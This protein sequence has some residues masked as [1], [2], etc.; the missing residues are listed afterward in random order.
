MARRT[1]ILYPGAVYHLM[2]RGNRKCPIFQNDD[3]R[4]TFVRTVARAVQRYDLRVYA[5]CLMDNH[6]HLLAETPRANIPAVMQYLNGVY[7]RA[8]N[9]HHQLTGHLF[10]DRYRALV[11]QRERYLR[12][13]ARY[14][15]LNP[16]RARLT[17][18]A[19]SWP[20][21]TYRATAG[22][23]PA[24]PWL[25]LSWLEWAFDANTEAEARSRYRSFVNRPPE[26]RWNIPSSA[27]AV[28]SRTFRAALEQHAHEP[29]RLLPVRGQPG[30]SQPGTPLSE[31]LAGVDARS[32][33]R[34][35]KIRLAHERHGFTLT[36]VARQ[37]G[38]D[39]STASKALKRLGQREVGMGD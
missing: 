10:G 33:D 38:I 30:G 27:I 11:V 34:D 15:V 4:R 9:R 25:D 7:A 28:G 14:I 8:F 39:R 21:S 37:L 13:V 18:N 20:W 12:R 29:D 19:E 6:Y 36:A 24:P 23:E 17:L 35:A 1:R 22:L 26:R 32:L 5:A 2:S 3:D 31:V 16:V